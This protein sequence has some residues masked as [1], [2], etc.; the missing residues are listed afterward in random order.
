[1]LINVIMFRL[2]L[3]CSDLTFNLIFIA[4]SFS[5][6]F[7]PCSSFCCIFLHHL[8]STS[9]SGHTSSA[10]SPAIIFSS[11]FIFAS[12]SSSYTIVTY[13]SHYLLLTL[14]ESLFLTLF[15]LFF[16][17][18]HET[19]FSLHPFRFI[20]LPKLPIIFCPGSFLSPVST[21]SYSSSSILVFSPAIEPSQGG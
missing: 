2:Q 10:S 6:S 8:P 5:P 16:S 15:I 9:S 7:L 17:S 13:F 18:S 20:S 3:I 4:L 19:H 1:M 11:I 21:S 12:P 14:P